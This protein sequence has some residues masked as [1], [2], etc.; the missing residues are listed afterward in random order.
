MNIGLV[1]IL[2]LTIQLRNIYIYIEIIEIKFIIK[3]YN[4]DHVPAVEI[5]VFES[6]KVSFIFDT[7]FAF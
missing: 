5:D 1:Q 2:I 7:Q 3:I 4:P 6:F